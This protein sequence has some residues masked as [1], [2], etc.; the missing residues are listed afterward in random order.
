MSSAAGF[1]T[2]QKNR[3]TGSAEQTRVL[4]MHILMLMENLRQNLRR[5]Q[6]NQNLTGTIRGT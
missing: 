2:E 5:T 1:C 3:V 4:L 6:R